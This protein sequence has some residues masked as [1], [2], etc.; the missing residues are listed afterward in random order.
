MPGHFTGFRRSTIEPSDTSGCF[1]ISVYALS[2]TALSM[3]PVE[4]FLWAQQLGLG[5]GEPG[6]NVQYCF[7]PGHV[8]SPEN[9]AVTLPPPSAMMASGIWPSASR[10]ACKTC[11]LAQMKRSRVRFHLRP[12]DPRQG[13]CT[14]P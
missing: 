3:E 12:G 4:Q 10:C 6:G 8:L 1:D 2:F 5:S 13:V 9:I 14:R 7:E 11:S